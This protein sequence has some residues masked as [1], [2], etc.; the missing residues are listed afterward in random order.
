MRFDGSEIKG[1]AVSHYFE[2]LLPENENIRNYLVRHFKVLPNN[3][4]ALL[5]T[6]GR[7]C[8]GAIQILG[9]N[10]APSDSATI[11]ALELTEHE[12]AQRLR[13]CLLPGI[14]AYEYEDDD[15]RI[16]L[17]GVQSKT[18]HLKYNNQWY[19]PRTITPTT[20]ILKL[21]MGRVGPMQVDFSNSVDNEWLCLKLGNKLGLDCAKAE[22]EVFEDQRVLVIERFDRMYSKDGKRIWR[23]PQEDFCQVLGWAPTMK[24]EADGGPGVQDIFKVLRHSVYAHEDSLR[25]LSVLVFFW[26]LRATDGH[27]KNFSINLLPHGN[28][29]LSKFYDIVSTWPAVG[30]GVHQLKLQKL[31]FAMALEGK[32]R[33]YRMDRINLSHFVRTAALA[34]IDESEV[35]EVIGLLL[36]SVPSACESVSKI[37][38]DDFSQ[39]V[40]DKVLE[41]VLKSSQELSEQID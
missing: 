25:F 23:L 6:I 2:N 22:I 27:A 39:K 14:A 9:E 7:D 36:Q 37:L 33:H 29:R 41:G 18:A 3:T 15:F 31:K 12:I 8:I 32:R 20:H 11:D 13:N 5:S 30:N 10:E 35:K 1:E 16:S 38:P 24:Y 26:L 19:A 21:P 34:G 40:A 28:Y 4:F 17:A